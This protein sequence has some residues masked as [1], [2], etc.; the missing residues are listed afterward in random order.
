MDLIDLRYRIAMERMREIPGENA[1]DPVFTDYFEQGARWFMQMQEH[2]RFLASE[3]VNTCSVDTLRDMNRQLYEEIRPGQYAHSYANPEYAV[4]KLGREYG[5]LLSSLRYEIRSVIPFVYRKE[6]ERFLI[7]AELF[8]E[9]YTSFTVAFADHGGRPAPENVRSIIYQYL[10]DYFEDE[11]VFYLR[12]QLV[13]GDKGIFR[14]I[15]ESIYYHPDLSPASHALELVRPNSPC[16]GDYVGMKADAASAIAK[17]RNCPV[18]F[19]GEGSRVVSV[20]RDKADSLSLVLK[21]G[22]IDAS[23]MPNLKGLSLK[24]ALEIAG[25][26]RMNVEYTGMGRVVSQTPKVG[27]TLRKGQICKLTLKEKG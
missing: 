5:A 6:K 26:I 12:D 23:T 18:S 1:A 2:A 17:S 16:K 21:L 20:R 25:N 13:C 7:R 15:M 10:A 27:E 19:E 22:D 4:N 14:R 11:M 3:E 8:L 24:D 9:V